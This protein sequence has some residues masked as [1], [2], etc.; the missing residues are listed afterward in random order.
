MHPGKKLTTNE[1]NPL[2]IC[3]FKIVDEH[4]A[5]SE[6][7]ALGAL[8]QEEVFQEGNE[9]IVFFGTGRGPIERDAGGKILRLPRESMVQMVCRQAIFPTC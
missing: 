7:T 5:W 6:F 4:G 2:P 1:I 3:D 8:D 9:V